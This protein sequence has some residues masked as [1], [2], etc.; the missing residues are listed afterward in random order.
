VDWWG[1][2]LTEA[3]GADRIFLEGKPGKEIT[4]EMSINKISKEKQK[5]LK[6]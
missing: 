2:T 1:C 6:S 5:I 3:E 4:F